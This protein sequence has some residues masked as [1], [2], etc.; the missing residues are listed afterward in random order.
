MVNRRSDAN[1]CA[2]HKQLSQWATKQNGRLYHLLRRHEKGLGQILALADPDLDEGR[3]P[4]RRE[5]CFDG[6]CTHGVTSQRRLLDEAIQRDEY[7]KSHRYS[8]MG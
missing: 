6:C 8:G 1:S 2:V 4:V 3:F 7:A 5:R